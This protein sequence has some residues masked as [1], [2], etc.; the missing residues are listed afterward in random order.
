MGNFIVACVAALIIA[1]AA[2]FVLN[3]FQEPA[4]EAFI[5]STSTRI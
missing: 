1:I 5:S 2:Y 4:S 3:N